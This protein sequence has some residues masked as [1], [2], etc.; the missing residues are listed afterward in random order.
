MGRCTS[1]REAPRRCPAVASFLP[2]RRATACDPRAEKGGVSRRGLSLDF[3]F[4]VCSGFLS[5]YLAANERMLSRPF[6]L[7]QKVTHWVGWRTFSN[8]LGFPRVCNNLGAKS[9]G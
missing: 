9:S 8:F 3:A 4:D 5:S 2:R 6:P 7:S 1:G